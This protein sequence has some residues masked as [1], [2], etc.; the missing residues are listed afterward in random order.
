MILRERIK[1]I[2]YRKPSWFAVLRGGH[3]RHLRQFSILCMAN[4][5]QVLLWLGTE[6]SLFYFNRLEFKALSG[7][8]CENLSVTALTFRIVRDT[9]GRG[10]DKGI[11]LRLHHYQQAFVPE[12]GFPKVAIQWNRGGNAMEPFF[13]T[14]KGDLLL[15]QEGLYNVD[16]DDGLSDNY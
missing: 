13:S 6:D 12:E 14:R 5:R 2:G 16:T 1:H 15:E 4:D 9:C 8:Q 11:I 3:N 7:R 10:T